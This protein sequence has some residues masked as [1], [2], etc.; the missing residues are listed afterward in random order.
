MKALLRLLPLTLPAWLP[1][2][3]FHHLLAYLLSQR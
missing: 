3:D 1:A 2:A